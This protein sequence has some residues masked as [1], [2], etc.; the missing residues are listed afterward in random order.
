MDNSKD[1]IN[2]LI[3]WAYLYLYG[4][5]VGLTLFYACNIGIATKP[6]GAMLLSLGAIA[7]FMLYVLI[8]HLFVKRVLASKI[9]FIFE[10]L[11]LMALICIFCG[12]LYSSNLLMNNGPSCL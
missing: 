7:L 4:G 11:L 3:P 9:L 2:N 5:F 6:V 10:T 8:N 1:S 12:D